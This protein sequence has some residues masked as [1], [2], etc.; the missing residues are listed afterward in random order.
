MEVS[1]RAS[2]DHWYFSFQII[3]TPFYIRNTNMS[4]NPGVVLDKAAIELGKT[5]E[6]MNIFVFT[7]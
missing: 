3:A 1:F 6:G 2:K 7:R 5:Q 4:N